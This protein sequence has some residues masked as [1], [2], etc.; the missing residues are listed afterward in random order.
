MT[1]LAALDARVYVLVG[2][3]LVVLL[4]I[5]L[6]RSAAARNAAGKT[7]PRAPER[8]PTPAAASPSAERRVRSRAPLT[9][10]VTLTRAAGG[11]PVRTFTM[12]VSD[13]GVLLAGPDDLAIGERVLIELDLRMADAAPVSCVAQ[14]VRSGASGEKAARFE[15]LSPAAAQSIRAL[16][17]A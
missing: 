14:V 3:A 1:L 7:T 2:G 10:P 8:E 15:G 12:D 13:D 6:T 4:F 11:A 9:R 17:A 16:R 5:A